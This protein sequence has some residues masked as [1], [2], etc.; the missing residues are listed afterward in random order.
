MSEQNEKVSDYRVLCYGEATIQVITPKNGTNAG[1]DVKVL[2]S[3]VFHPVSVRNNDGTFT[4]QE[5]IWYDLKL[6]DNSVD[7][8]K[9]FFKDGLVLRVS[10]EIKKRSWVGKDGKERHGADLM[11]YTV[12]IDIKQR[13]LKSVVFEKPIKKEG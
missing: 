12:A 10:G 6:F 11:A 8:L 2:T 7:L 13:G 3:R 9:D 4:E 1:K 5:P